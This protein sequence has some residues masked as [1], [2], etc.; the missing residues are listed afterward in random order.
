MF[1]RILKIYHK[2]ILLQDKLYPGY[3]FKFNQAQ[4]NGI[5]KF[6]FNDGLKAFCKPTSRLETVYKDELSFPPQS[7]KEYQRIQVIK[8]LLE[9]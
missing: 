6:D 5:V 4:P 7:Y 3:V 9:N 8:W 1:K 2:K